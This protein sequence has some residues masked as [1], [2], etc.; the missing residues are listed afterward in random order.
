MNKLV[1]KLLSADGEC[2]VKKWWYVQTFTIEGRIKIG[3]TRVYTSENESMAAIRRFQASC[4]NH[5]EST[6]YNVKVI[7]KIPLQRR[8][9]ALWSQ[10]L[11]RS[12]GFLLGGDYSRFIDPTLHTIFMRS[13]CF[14]QYT[15]SINGS[16]RD[17][18]IKGC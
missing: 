15:D 2:L 13:G 1:R 9:S 16:R 8:I 12:G 4:L 7:Y 5:H 3:S 6:V 18:H 14:N 17:C 11:L 10:H